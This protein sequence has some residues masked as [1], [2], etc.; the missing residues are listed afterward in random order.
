MM[1]DIDK[2]TQRGIAAMNHIML[3]HKRPDSRVVPIMKLVELSR[4]HNHI[5]DNEDCDHNYKEL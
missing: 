1:V 5:H 4:L 3:E 2:E